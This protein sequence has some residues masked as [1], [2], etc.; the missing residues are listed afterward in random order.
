MYTFQSH[1]LLSKLLFDFSG[2]REELQLFEHTG[3]THPG[4]GEVPDDSSLALSDSTL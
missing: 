1:F 3:K 4:L 2:E